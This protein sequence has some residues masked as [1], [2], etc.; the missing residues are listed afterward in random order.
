MPACPASVCKVFVP[1]QTSGISGLLEA[2]FPEEGEST[3]T[4]SW[5]E[6]GEGGWYACTCLPLTNEPD[7]LGGSVF[8][9]S[10]ERG[11]L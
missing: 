3:S 4:S 8:S 10:Q 1:H 2:S 7:H 5:T 6:S 9:P 11:A